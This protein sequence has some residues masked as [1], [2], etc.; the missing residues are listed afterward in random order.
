MLKPMLH[1]ASFDDGVVNI[2][3][4]HSSIQC[5]RQTLFLM[6]NHSQFFL[7]VHNI[8]NNKSGKTKQ[9][10]DND[11]YTNCKGKKKKKKETTEHQKHYCRT[12]RIH[13]KRTNQIEGLGR[14][15]ANLP[16]KTLCSR[17]FDVGWG[18]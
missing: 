9:N 17:D 12:I 13:N 7:V 5:F 16:P 1:S 3:L 2:P 11:Y 10:S 6:V 14:E 4:C 15:K 8:C 18:F